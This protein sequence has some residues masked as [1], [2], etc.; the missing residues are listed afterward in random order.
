MR[1]TPSRPYRDNLQ[2]AASE[3]KAAKLP[4]LLATLFAFL[5]FFGPVTQPSEAADDQGRTLGDVFRDCT[6]CPEMVVVRR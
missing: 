4:H 1:S 6:E 3:L 2:Q 5:V